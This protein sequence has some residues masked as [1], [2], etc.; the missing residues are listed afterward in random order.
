M[1][2]KN[3]KNRELMLWTDQISQDLS[4]IKITQQMNS[5]ANEFLILSI[6]DMF[7]VYMKFGGPWIRL[8]S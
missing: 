4:N 2:K 7:R 6:Y 8:I 1:W 3:T 5:A